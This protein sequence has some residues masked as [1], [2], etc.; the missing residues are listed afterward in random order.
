V[1]PDFAVWAPRPERVALLVRPASEPGSQSTVVAM[2][3]DEEGWWRPAE[4]L[5]AFTAGDVR[6]GYLLDDAD[7]P[8]PDPRSRRQPD[9]V[10]ALSQSFNPAAFDWSDDRWNGRQLAGGVMYELHVGTFTPAGTLISAIER[11]DHLVELGV[12]FVELMPV[13]AFNGT[14]GWGYDG[15]AWYAVHE[16]YGGPAAYQQFVDACHSRGLAVIQDVV[17][18]HLGPS[19][20]YLP[21]Y[22]PYL[23]ENAAN[24]WG[25]AIN[26]DGEHSDEVRQYILDNAAM[27]LRDYHVDGLRLDAVHALYDA[28]AV[29]ILEDL[30]METGGL[31][32]ALGKPFPL[33]AESDLNDPRLITSREAGGYGLTAQW[34]DDFHHALYVSLTGDKTGYYADFDS[35]AALA[36]V[37]EQGFFHTGTRSSFRGRTH[38]HPI[39]TWRTATWRLVV[40]SDNHDQIGNRADGMRLSGKIDDQQLAVAAVITLL[41][42][43]TPMIFMGEEWGARTPWQFF[44]SHPEP[45]LAE[46]I[47]TGRLEEFAAMDWDTSAVPD[48]QDPATFERSKLNWGELDSERSAQL[49]DL[50]RRL[51]QL[52]R[53]HPDLTDPRFD[54]STTAFDHLRGW[55]LVERG[56]MIIVANFSDELAKIELPFAIEPLLQVGEATLSG[57]PGEATLSEPPSEATLSRPQ[58]ELAPHTAVVGAR[59]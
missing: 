55:L 1:S 57:P 58:A 10:H 20:N 51:I 9:G 24:T 18:N 33:I 25:A 49:L 21:Q 5:P 56:E 44:T 35:A 46:L 11:L 30:A 8:L 13:N 52:R 2:E 7:T 29:H 22:G 12:D 31:S 4:T 26:L 54:H 39:D 50:S 43:F 36:K 17:Y 6:Y 37:F 48:P 34:S 38:G 32:A 42:P 16:P 45:E 40:C 47:R 3:R 27:W 19:G 15:V 28:R 53:D 59:A 41:S 23:T 14:H